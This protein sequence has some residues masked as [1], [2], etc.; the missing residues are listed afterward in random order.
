MES[1]KWSCLLDDSVKE[2][3]IEQWL[4]N[5]DITMEV[6]SGAADLNLIIKSLFSCLEEYPHSKEIQSRSYSLLLEA[7]TLSDSSINVYDEGPRYTGIIESSLR[8]W[9]SHADI[10]S[11]C[12]KYLAVAPEML[13][14]HGELL[15]FVFLVINTHCHSTRVQLPGIQIL[16]NL[17][18]HSAMN[19]APVSEFIVRKIV[20]LMIYNLR[21]QN[22]DFS[23]SKIC[24]CALEI[25]VRNILPQEIEIF[26][27]DIVVLVS[28]V[29]HRYHRIPEISSVC[30]III[31]KLAVAEDHLLTFCSSSDQ[32]FQIC[33]SLRGI[34]CSTK[35]SMSISAACQLLNR[36]ITNKTILDFILGDDVDSG[37]HF[38]S[39][40]QT[41][42]SEHLGDLNS[43][44]CEWGLSSS[45]SCE[46]IASAVKVLSAVDDML[47]SP[48]G[49][50]K[51]VVTSGSRAVAP[52]SIESEEDCTP[53]SNSVCISPGRN[54]L[55]LYGDHVNDDIALAENSFTGNVTEGTGIVYEESTHMDDFLCQGFSKSLSTSSLPSE[56]EA[57]MII[58]VAQQSQHQAAVAM[59]RADILH[60][61]FVDATKKM[62]VRGRTHLRCLHLHYDKSCPMKFERF[63]EVHQF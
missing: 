36:S 34:K 40:L 12:L 6:S 32:L 49:R 5:A 19:S 61:L 55:H 15:E 9:T 27:D 46:I 23:I 8:N 58:E 4:W 43:L 50:S 28:Q 53:D 45:Q 16:Y 33:E 62:E 2:R 51:R 14:G 44:C 29:F 18:Q 10:V 22:S 47:Q 24:C 11:I 59:V 20:G 52:R 60:K 25:V 31:E 17:L 3:V 54:L 7:H 38:L 48:S 42:L 35:Y 37:L 63:N 56:H 21:F 41:H 26:G 1:I 57:T 39:D 30:L 13:N